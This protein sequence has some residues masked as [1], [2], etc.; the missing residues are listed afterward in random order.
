MF[1][2]AREFQVSGPQANSAKETFFVCVFISHI[3][4]VKLRNLTK[5][6]RLQVFL[7]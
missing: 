2:V 6:F 7:K 4:F 5:T 3:M 1:S